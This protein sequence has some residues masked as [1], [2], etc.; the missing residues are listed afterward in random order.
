MEPT[1]YFLISGASRRAPGIEETLPKTLFS[2]AKVAPTLTRIFGY[3]KTALQPLLFKTSRE[4]YILRTIT[5]FLSGEFSFGAQ[6]VDIKM[7]SMK[8]D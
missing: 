7:T 2:G 8:M 1:T 4:I 3:P 6:N 5:N